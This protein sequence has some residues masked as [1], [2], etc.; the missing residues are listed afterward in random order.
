L[1]WQ[2]GNY[3]NLQIGKLFGFKTLIS[4]PEGD[5]HQKENGV[6]EKFSKSDGSH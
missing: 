6:R 5:H 3:T 2:E 4:E 1:F